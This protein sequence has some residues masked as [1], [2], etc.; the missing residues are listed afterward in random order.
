MLT[1]DNERM[2]SLLLELSTKEIT[3]EEL[4]LKCAEWTTEIIDSFHF[5]PIPARP[6]E[7]N[8]L[9]EVPEEKRNLLDSNFYN[10][11]PQILNYTRTSQQIK[12]ENKALYDWLLECR[13]LLMDAMDLEA[14]AKIDSKLKESEWGL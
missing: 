5:K 3:V 8:I 10:V 6:D 14:A 4:L 12:Y 9:E 7:M 1:R 2:K 13:R 11:Y